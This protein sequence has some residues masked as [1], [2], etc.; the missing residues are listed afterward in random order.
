MGLLGTNFSEILIEIENFSFTKMHL[1]ISSA[2]WWPFCPKGCGCGCGVV[3][4]LSRL[5]QRGPYK[6]IMFITP[7]YLAGKMFA[8][9]A[10][11]G[12]RERVIRPAPLS[13]ARS[14]LEKT[15]TE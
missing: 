14:D 1:K 3:G 5:S 6:M 8:I 4:E 15:G 10:V 13:L 7:Q 12:G 11:Q 2:K 9:M